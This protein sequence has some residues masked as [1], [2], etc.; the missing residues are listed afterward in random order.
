MNCKIP[1]CPTRFMGIVFS[2]I[3]CDDELV[4]GTILENSEVIYC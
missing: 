3:I 1:V 4:E 2:F